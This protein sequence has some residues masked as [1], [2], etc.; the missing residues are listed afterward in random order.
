[1]NHSR[2]K[3]LPLLDFTYL[4]IVF[5]VVIFSFTAEDIRLYLKFNLRRD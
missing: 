4:V 2:T 5:V 1:M 3:H